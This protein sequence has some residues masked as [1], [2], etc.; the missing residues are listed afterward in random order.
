MIIKTNTTQRTNYSP[1]EPFV[2]EL[3]TVEY[4]LSGP[5]HYTKNGKPYTEV[6]IEARI[7]GSMH[8]MISRYHA[9]RP[10]DQFNDSINLRPAE[11]DDEL[12]YGYSSIQNICPTYHENYNAR[13][14]INLYLTTLLKE[15]NE[16]LTQLLGNAATS[17]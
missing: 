1:L 15:N 8:H 17:H 13:L 3:E 12:N 9:G 16:L 5:Y 4:D 10:Y 14:V 11:I 7:I 6:S 2:G